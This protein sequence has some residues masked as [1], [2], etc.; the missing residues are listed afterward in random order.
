VYFWVWPR[1][2]RQPDA[3]AP[4]R[5]NSE[6]QE[7]LAAGKAA[8]QEGSYALALEK[9]IDAHWL[10]QRDPKALTYGESQQ[11]NR[12]YWECA[13]YANLVGRGPT[14]RV[15]ADL[16]DEA[17]EHPNPDDW[18][19][20]FRRKYRAKTVIFDGV[21]RFDRRARTLDRSEVRGSRVKARISIEGLQLF[22]YLPK[23]PRRWIFGARLASVR[24]EGEAGWVIRLEPDSGVL[25]T[26]RQALVTW[27]PALANDVEVDDVLQRQRDRLPA[28][29][30][31]EPPP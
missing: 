15:L 2:V 24:D 31:T 26:D 28:L 19:A 6:A 9:L 16:L 3:A 13:L 4:A 11:L 18:A 25:L 27:N 20:H 10:C 21:V 22:D 7:R 5:K 1:L 29:P 17:G 30:A 23:E 14:E 12:I 8:F